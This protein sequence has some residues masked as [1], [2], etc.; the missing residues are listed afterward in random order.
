MS[1]RHS[2]VIRDVAKALGLQWCPGCDGY[3]VEEVTVFHDNVLFDEPLCAG[4]V[5]FEYMQN[6]LDN[7]K[8]DL[9]PTIEHFQD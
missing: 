5:E 1:N 9:G 2:K 7:L 3:Y 6:E 4:C 8:S